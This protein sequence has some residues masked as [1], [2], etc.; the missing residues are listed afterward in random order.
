MAA[1][2]PWLA[3]AAAA[4]YPA[5]PV[6]TDRRLHAGRPSDVLARIVGKKIG[7]LL[8]QPIVDREKPGA[9][10]Q[11][12]GRTGR[13][14]C[15]RRLHAADGNNSILAHQCEPVQENQLRRREGF[16]AI[17]LIGSQANILVVNPALPVNRWPS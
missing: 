12:R 14:R 7:E 5:R 2:G 13:A 1:T 3:P 9:R 8:G 10:R 16:R 11:Y 15:A 4:E 17:S 6:S